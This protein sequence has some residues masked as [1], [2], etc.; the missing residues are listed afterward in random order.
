MYSGWTDRALTDSY[1][2]IIPAYRD[3]SRVGSLALL[4][5]VWVPEGNE[6]GRAVA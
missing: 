1:A 6:L 5:F 3:L 2:S 4:T